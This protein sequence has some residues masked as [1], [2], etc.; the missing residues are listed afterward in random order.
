M[1]QKYVLILLALLL[2]G[3]QS[4]LLKINPLD[5]SESDTQY[6][7]H[8]AAMLLPLSGASEKVGESLQNAAL[9]SKL[10]RPN[11]GLSLH[12][13]DTKGTADGAQEALNEALMNHPDLIIGPVFSSEVKAVASE[14]PSASVIS[15]TSDTNAVTSD[16]F[17]M[18]LLIPAQVNRMIQFACESGKRELAVIGPENKTGEIVMN[19]L[20]EAIKT[21]PDMILKKV[22]LYDPKTINLDPAVS[23]IAPP[24]IDTRKK[25][26]TEEEKYQLS[27][28]PSERIDFDALFIYE[29]GAKAQQLASLLAYYDVTPS[30]VDVYGLAVLKQIQDKNLEG[31]YFPD[32]PQEKW[33]EFEKKYQTVFGQKPHPLASFGYDAVSLASYLSMINAYEKITDPIGYTGINGQFRFLPNGT[34]QRLLEVYR[35]QSK[36]KHQKVS[37]AP[38]HYEDLSSSTFNFF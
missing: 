25:D 19:T 2:S 9:L 5:Q 1:K 26:L 33:L 8:R 36:G 12:F 4:S 29:E 11:D 6:T 18:G 28:P 34:N 16:V 24:F 13:Y 14:N 38:L 21:C 37:S 30:V 27:L 32:M 3:C 7:M 20:S 17:T 35:I 23:K 31:A 15:F 10:E 22:S